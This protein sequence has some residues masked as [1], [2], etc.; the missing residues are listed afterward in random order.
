MPHAAY[1]KREEYDGA[2]F[3]EGVQQDLKHGLNV[4]APYH[5]IEVLDR[6]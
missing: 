2:V 4:G 1:D 3:A 6:E 5:A